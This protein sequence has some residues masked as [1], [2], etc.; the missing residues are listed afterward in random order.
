MFVGHLQ[1][2]PDFESKRGA[3]DGLKEN[4]LEI[5]RDIEKGFVPVAE[6]LQLQE[7]AI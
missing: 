6:A 3:L 4:L 7:L 1:E 5:Y 2:S